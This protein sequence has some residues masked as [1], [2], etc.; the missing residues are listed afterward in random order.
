M[1]ETSLNRTPSTSPSKIIGSLGIISIKR[2]IRDIM[3]YRGGGCLQKGKHA[4]RGTGQNLQREMST[5]EHMIMAYWTFTL[6]HEKRKKTGFMKDMSM[7][8]F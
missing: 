8:T 2:G 7:V 5:G 1:A 3:N 4:C 6:F